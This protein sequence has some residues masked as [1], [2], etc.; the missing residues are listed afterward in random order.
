MAT[1]DTDSNKSSGFTLTTGKMVGIG[2]LLLLLGIVAVGC[3]KYSSFVRHENAIEAEQL[4]VEN[5][6]AAF[7]KTVKAEGGVFVQYGDMIK[8]II[9]TNKVSTFGADG[10][11]QMFLMLK[12]SYPNMEPGIATKLQQLIEAGFNK[13]ESR[14]TDKIDECKAY[15]NEYGTPPGNIVAGIFG[16]PRVNIKKACAIMTSAETKHD[17]EAG[18]LSDAPVFEPKPASSAK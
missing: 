8:E 18:E 17:V 1:N 15:K 11:K 4:E 12:D 7:Y 3:S 5:T 10:A 9:R 2:L 14:Q 6:H 16:F 13:I